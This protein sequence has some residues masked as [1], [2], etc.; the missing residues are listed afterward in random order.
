[1]TSEVT[2]LEG[3][4]FDVLAATEKD[5]MSVFAEAMSGL[6]TMADQL[7]LKRMG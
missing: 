5:W 3:T 2:A 1:L 7:G 6:T 4:R